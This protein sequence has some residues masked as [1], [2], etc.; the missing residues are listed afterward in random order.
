MAE[1]GIVFVD[2]PIVP[3]QPGEV[4]DDFAAAVLAIILPHVGFSNTV[5]RADI[6]ASL[7]R[8]GFESRDLDR[9]MRL[10]V[11]K[12]R[13]A[14]YDIITDPSGAGWCMC[15]SLDEAV[16]WAEHKMLPN[17][18]STYRTVNAVLT[19][20][21]RKYPVKQLA[22]DALLAETARPTAPTVV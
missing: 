2:D 22:M 7:R 12:L 8:H 4:T 1:R 19:T 9:K 20:V 3:A 17:A 11:E 5:K 15:G 14:G 6:L 13:N 21:R 10:A 16:E 18:R